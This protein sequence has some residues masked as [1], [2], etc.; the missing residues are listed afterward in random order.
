MKASKE[1]SG[2]TGMHRRVAVWAAVAAMGV[3][4]VA[5]AFPDRP[6]R[7]VVGFPPGASD[8]SARIVAQKMSELWGQPVVV[9]NRPGAAGNIGA[10]QVAAA[11]PDGYTILL[12]VNSYTINTTVYRNLKWGLLRDFTAIGRYATSPMV[13]VVNDQLPV[14]TVADLISYAKQNP[15]VLNYGSAGTGTAPHLAG[16]LFAERSG[17]KMVH[18]PY[19]G[20]APS[21]T[22]LMANE[23]QVAFGAMSAFDG[24]VHDGR[25]RPLAV[26]TADRF[27]Q[28]PQVPTV[29]ESGVSDFDLDI[30]YGLLAPAGTPPDI[31]K[32][33]SDTLER[34]VADP[35]IQEKLRERGLQAAYLTSSDTTALMK[36]DVARWAEIAQRLN[37]SLE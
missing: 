3:S 14:K 26:T 30:W 15:G 27:S 22:A 16:E 33:L 18:V 10:T 36:R 29:M 17:T 12:A 28:L 13:V 7:L 6:V 9:E 23:V 2:P 24:A 5:F 37:L 21:V 34:A 32:I 25:V 35:A 11:K 20:S 1:K 4:G 31:V 19:K 8:L